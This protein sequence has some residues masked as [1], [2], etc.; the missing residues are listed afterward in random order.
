MRTGA[1][2]S[3]PLIWWGLL[4]GGQAV[5]RRV[6]YPIELLHVAIQLVG[7][8]ALIRMGVFVLRHS[9]SPGSRLKAWEGALTTTIWLIVALRVTGLMPLVAEVLSD[10]ALEIGA[11]QISLYTVVS[12]LLSAVLLLLLALWIANALRALMARSEALDEGLKVALY[13]LAKFL[14]LVLALVVALVTAGVDLTALAVF[15][16]ALGVGLGLG[17]QRIVSNFV[18]GVILSFEGAI[19]PGDV[20]ETN[21]GF[22]TV[23][24]LHA[25]YTAIQNRDGKHMLI[26][27]EN[28]LTSQI[29]N[30]SYGDRDVRFRLPI[31]ISY[32]DDPEQALA[33]MERA[34]RETE[35]V[36]V[37]PPPGGRL[38]GFGESGIDLELRLWINDPENG[39]N[40][41]R[42]DV[43]RRIWRAFQEAGI[44]IPFPQREVHIKS[45]GAA[46]GPSDGT[47][48]SRPR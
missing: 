25:R 27:N 12:F 23:T 18:S 10:H 47:A 46:N 32:G 6:A 3:V 45:A 22:G 20:I 40:N 14:L 5:L 42:S 17:L 7:A 9:F 19:R 35:R 29:T 34:A 13:K 15:G 26:P 4:L 39:V 43:Y 36:L 38:M 21:E 48:G 37:E 28:L 33:L 31:Q 30:W 8:L 24:G 16:G 2:A 41:V 44:T 11:A 1:L